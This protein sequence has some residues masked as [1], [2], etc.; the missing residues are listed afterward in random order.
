MNGFRLQGHLGFPFFPSLVSPLILLFPFRVALLRVDGV[1]PVINSIGGD[2]MQVVNGK[3]E[4][5]LKA[6]REY[7]FCEYEARMYYS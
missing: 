5:I 2:W 6:L 1:L 3:E 4:R 7:G